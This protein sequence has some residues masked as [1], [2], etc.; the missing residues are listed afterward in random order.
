MLGANNMI[1]TIIIF[2]LALCCTFAKSSEGDKIMKFRIIY[3]PSDTITIKTKAN[4][5]K[6][7][8]SETKCI[9]EGDSN[10]EINLNNIQEIEPYSM[11]G[12]GSM[13]KMKYDNKP[14]FLSVVRLNIGGFF[15]IVN[16]NGTI[17]LY[18]L[19]KKYTKE[20]VKSP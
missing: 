2:M 11:P 18:N 19:L 17:K 5:G 1:K 8:I 14:L 10:F 9:I 16:R 6:L 4:S 12:T 7:E 13:I 3:V 15:V 20:K